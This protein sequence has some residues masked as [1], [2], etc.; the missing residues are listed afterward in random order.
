MRKGRWLQLVRRR[1]VLSVVLSPRNRKRPPPT[2]VDQKC[3][4]F[5]HLVQNESVI[6]QTHQEEL[7]PDEYYDE[8]GPKLQEKFP[9]ADPDLV[10]HAVALLAAFDTAIAFALSF[11]I[12]KFQLAQARV[13]LVGEIVSREGRS[14]NPDLVKAIRGRR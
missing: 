7:P 3:E 8:L 12:E 10:E 13:K 11:G 6:A 4:V 14:L 1:S 5:C 2:S 9:N